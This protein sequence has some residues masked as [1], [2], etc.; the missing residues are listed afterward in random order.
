[1]RKSRFGRQGQAAREQR[2][3]PTGFRAQKRR[4]FCELDGQPGQKIIANDAELSF[5]R[6]KHE[7]VPGEVKIRSFNA[8]KRNR[9]R[10]G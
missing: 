7:V 5:S 3:G 6:L 10:F 1:M 4:A 8:R 2:L 9:G